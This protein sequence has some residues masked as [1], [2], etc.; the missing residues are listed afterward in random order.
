MDRCADSYFAS[1]PAALLLLRHGLRFIGVIKTATKQYPYK[2]LHNKVLCE[3]GDMYGLIRK[4]TNNEECDLLAF[5]WV[6][7][8][9]CRYFIATGLSL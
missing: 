5:V 1:V 2:V 9:G 4:K 6:V 8:Q 3:R 7:D